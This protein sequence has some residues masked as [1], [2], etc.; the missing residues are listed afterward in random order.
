[1]FVLLFAPEVYI[2]CSHSDWPFSLIVDANA[3]EREG[4]HYRYTP[5]S[6]FHLSVD[7]LVSLLVEVQSEKS[8]G[9]RYRMLLQAACVA[10][11][12]RQLLDDDESKPFIV[13]A[14][15][16]KNNGTALR[17]LV[18]QP[19]RLDPNVCASESEQSCDFSLV[20][21]FLCRGRTR[22]DA[23]IPAV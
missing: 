19:D 21:G 20:L 6:D 5:R 2:C 14:L 23:T 22:L 12:G 1:L 7:C 3:I 4:K 8:E 9:D 16:V 17:N 18:F 15:Y 10:R 13:V 11:L